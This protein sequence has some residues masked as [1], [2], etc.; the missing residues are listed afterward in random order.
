MPG[1]HPD[2]VHAPSMFAVWSPAFSRSHAVEKEGTVGW[3]AVFTMKKQRTATDESGHPTVTEMINLKMGAGVSNISFTSRPVTGYGGVSALSGFFQWKSLRQT[4]GKSLP[5]QTSSPNATPLEEIVL[6]YLIGMLAGAKSLSQL[7]FLRKDRALAQILALGSFPSQS[8]LTRFFQ[9][10]TQAHN[11]RFFSPL[12]RWSLNSLVSRAEGYTLDF[13][14]TH[15]S[16]DDNEQNEGLETGYTPE[17]FARNYHPLIAVLG[18]VDLVAGFWLRRGDTRS[19]NNIIAFTKQVLSHLPSH[20]RIGLI[21]ADSGFLEPDWLEFLEQERL[22]YIVV[23]RLFKPLKRLVQTTKKWTQTS[24]PGIEV[25]EELY[26]GWKWPIQRRIVL[27]RH[28]MQKRPQAGGKLLFDDKA[29]R[30]QVLMTNLPLSVEGL[31][32]WRRYNGRAGL[33]NVVKELDQN[34]ALPKTTLKSFWA[35]E[36]ALSLSVLSYNLSVMFQQ[37]FKWKHP[38]RADTLRYRLFGTPAILITKARKTI[39]RLAVVGKEPRNWWRALFTKLSSQ[40]PNCN[41]VEDLVT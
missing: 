21:R 33:E 35:T 40:F 12:W 5:F 19:D 22:S 24:V 17:G 1:V 26:E 6:G 34:F 2:T 41:A 23:A 30:Y 20:I 13:D 27:I 4:I 37:F 14:S 28:E 39:L 11:H 10:F 18:E 9:R 8:T 25:A 7:A 31:T 29:Y 3:N 36:A 16:H 15:L 32:V 38:V